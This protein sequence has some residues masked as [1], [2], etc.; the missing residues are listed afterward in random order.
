[1]ERSVVEESAED[2]DVALRVLATSERRAVLTCFIEIGDG[3]VDLKDLAEYVAAETKEESIGLTVLTLL[4][5]DLPYLEAAGFV[6]FDFRS[7]TVVGTDAIH[8][9]KPLLDAACRV[10]QRTNS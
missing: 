9:L 3:A 2:I 10:E 5:C 4:H 7:E 8:S 6:E 1:M